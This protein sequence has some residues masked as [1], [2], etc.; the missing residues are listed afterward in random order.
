MIDS[1]LIDV[2]AGIGRR[3]DGMF[4]FIYILPLFGYCKARVLISS[5]YSPI[6]NY[7]S[8]LD[9]PRSAVR[10]PCQQTETQSAQ[11]HPSTTPKALLITGR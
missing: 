10:G 8:P 3:V 9:T 4:R 5:S 6:P 2:I 1:K 11:R 7:P